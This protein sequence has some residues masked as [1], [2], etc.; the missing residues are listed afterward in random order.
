MAIWKL[1]LYGQAVDDV[2]KWYI[3]GNELGNGLKAGLGVENA[4][5]TLTCPQI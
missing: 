4:G 1:D 3:W 5:E 2:D